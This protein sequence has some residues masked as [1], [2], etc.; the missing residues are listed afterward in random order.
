MLFATIQHSHFSVISDLHI[1]HSEELKSHKYPSS[2][3]VTHCLQPSLKNLELNYMAH[4]APVRDNLIFSAVLSSPFG[5][6]LFFTCVMTAAKTPA[7][8]GNLTMAAPLRAGTE[9][10]V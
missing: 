7:S 9:K 1:F 6:V 2:L 10:A 8:P 3:P 5:L 4:M